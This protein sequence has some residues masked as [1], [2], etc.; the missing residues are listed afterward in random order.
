MKALVLAAGYGT[1]LY[2]LTTLTSKSLLRISGKPLIEHIIMRIEELQDI[3]EVL[4]VTNNRFFPDF[5][6]WLNSYKSAVKV[7]LLNDMTRSNEDRLGAVGD[8]DFAVKA[9]GIDD[10]LL[11]IAGD[12][13]FEF[14]LLGMYRFF[15]EKKASV[16]ALHEMKDPE[17][18]AG[19]FGVAELDSDFRIIGFEEKPSN[20]KSSLASTACYFFTRDDLTELER[21]IAAHQKPDNLGDFIRWLSSKASVYG[22]VFSEKWFDIGSHEHL[23]EADVHFSNRKQK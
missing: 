12:N 14:S 22:F 6:N 10:D 18:V 15:R 2:P 23:K 9:A 7:R 3:D 8:I 20:P 5:R 17:R 13:L 16:V 1:R 21:C 4:V 11:V 19:K